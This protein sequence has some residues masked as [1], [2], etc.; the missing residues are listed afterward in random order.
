MPVQLRV[1]ASAKFTMAQ[2]KPFIHYLRPCSKTVQAKYRRRNGVIVDQHAPRRNCQ[3]DGSAIVQVMYSA[4]AR[5][6]RND[7]SMCDRPWGG[8]SFHFLQLCIVRT[9]S[10]C[11]TSVAAVRQHRRVCCR[12]RMLPGQKPELPRVRIF[13]NIVVRRCRGFERSYLYA[14]G[15]LVV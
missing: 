13:V 1:S 3:R 5:K 10:M 4:F 15:T 8:G 12:G 9:Q 6:I 7:F 14:T 2:L 11:R